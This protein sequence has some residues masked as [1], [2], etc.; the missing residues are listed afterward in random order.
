MNGIGNYQLSETGKVEVIKCSYPD[1]EEPGEYITY[2][3]E[4]NIFTRDM[5]YPNVRRPLNLQTNN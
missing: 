5:L 4:D 2:I 3:Y 1:P